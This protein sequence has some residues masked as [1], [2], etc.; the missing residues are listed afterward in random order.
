MRLTFIF[1]AV[2]AASLHASGAALPSATASKIAEVEND[3]FPATA[4]SAHADGGGMLRRIEKNDKINEERIDFL[5]F[6]K[7]LTSKKIKKAENMT[8]EELTKW[9]AK[10][11]K[12]MGM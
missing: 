3:A 6:W 10:E 1:A 12:K 2:I 4:D 9:L 8:P 7:A 5:K 11:A